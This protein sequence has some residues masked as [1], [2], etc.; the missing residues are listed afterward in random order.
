MHVPRPLLC[1]LLLVAACGTAWAFVSPAWQT[2]DEDVHFAY[3]ETLATQQRLPGG[4]S[5]P[6]STAQSTAIDV[7]NV[8]ATTFF[9]FA[10]PEWSQTAY[11]D[12]RKRA[13]GYRFDDG[14]GNSS[15]SSYPPAFYL[16]DAVFYTLGSAGDVLTRFY[17]ARLG[18]VVLLLLTTL[19]VWLLAGELFHRRRLPQLVAAASVGLWP[20]ITF[21]SSSVN[22]DAMLLTTWTLIFW[23]AA[24]VIGRGLN[25]LRGLALGTVLG[26]TVL[27]KTASVV[28]VPCGLAL[29]VWLSWRGRRHRS[30]LLGAASAVAAFLLP[31]VAWIL[32][33]RS[34]SGGAAF[35]QATG[36]ASAQG[37]DLRELA[38]YLWQFYLPNLP[39]MTPVQHHFPIASD[40]PVLNTWVGMNW[41]VYGWANVWWPKTWYLVAY[42][43]TGAFA[44]GGLVVGA[45]R[46]LPAR[47]RRSLPAGRLTLLVF[48]AVC[49]LAL[50]AGVHWTDY[51][52]YAEGKGPFA[53]GRYLL[54]VAAL[55][56]LLVAMVLDAL[57]RRV[58]L[59]VVG[60][61]LGFLIV[62]QIA[63]LTL[64]AD[65]FYG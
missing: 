38:S 61:W 8:P 16:Y 7:T 5:A 13:S 21:T 27:T 20:A 19:G 30:A 50:A 36:N 9:T 63:S 24:V 49:A 57:P 64:V 34:A 62:L 39:F 2:P 65:R 26:I 58:R 55:A 4:P 12:W 15:A 10:H 6:F 37:I 31:V 41:G 40:L 18:S 52:F 60:A 51:K 44:I 28:L 1:L 47:R 43:V 56:G 33:V 45:R 46:L 23:L 32:I 25:P 22:P 14:G 3:V 42:L 54:P 48:L 11:E 17:A 29:L 59:P 35:G 53:Q